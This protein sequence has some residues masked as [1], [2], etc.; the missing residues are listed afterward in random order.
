MTV[1]YLDAGGPLRLLVTSTADGA[2]KTQLDIEAAQFRQLLDSIGP[3]D[4]IVSS[5][6]LKVEV[7]RT[8]RREGIPLDHGF[9]F[10]TAVGLFPLRESDLDEAA[11]LPVRALRALDALHLVAAL[12]IRAHVLLSYDNQLVGAARDLGLDTMS[13]GRD[14]K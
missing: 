8:L 7:L 14:G 2:T 4:R 10:L 9:E 5:S 13:P 12:R 11:R 3:D 1:Y 6:L